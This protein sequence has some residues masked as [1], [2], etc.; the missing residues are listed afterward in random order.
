MHGVTQAGDGDGCEWEPQG[1]FEMTYGGKFKIL[2][3][4]M[5][6]HHCRWPVNKF[7]DSYGFMVKHPWIWRLQFRS[8]GAFCP[9]FLARSRLHC[10]SRH[11]WVF[12]RVVGSAG[13]MDRLSFQ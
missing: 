13:G 6:K 10:R 4:D 11:G 2:I 12:R 7:G 9:G 1:A 3:V 8:S 5:W